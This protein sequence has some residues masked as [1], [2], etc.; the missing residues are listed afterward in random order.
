M[1]NFFFIII[2]LS[3]LLLLIR[4][5]NR[6]KENYDVYESEFLENVSEEELPSKINLTA[7]LENGYVQ[8][9]WIPPKL[10]IKH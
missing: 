9:H 1:L 5:N 7:K 6:N 10:D 8:L 2:I 3:L 4:W